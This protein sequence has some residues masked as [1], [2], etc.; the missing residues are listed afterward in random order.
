MKDQVAGVIR[1]VAKAYAV[2]PSD[3]TGPSRG[4]RVVMARHVA[5]YV[6]RHSYGM[7]HSAVAE[8]L[9]RTNHT[10]ALHAVRSVEE[11][12]GR[13]RVF[14]GMVERMCEEARAAADR[15]GIARP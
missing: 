1:T 4:R 10:T 8:G 11:K 2:R 12:V 6:L 7:P 9:G 15:R 13:D 3:M 14:A 5:M